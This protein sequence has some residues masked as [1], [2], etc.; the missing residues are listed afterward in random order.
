MTNEIKAVY[1]KESSWNKEEIEFFNDMF[2]DLN[3]PTD[4]EL[5]HMYQLDLIQELLVDDGNIKNTRIYLV[6]TNEFA[7]V[8]NEKFLSLQDSDL[9]YEYAPF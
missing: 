3:E 8:S 5:E 6:A 9:E 4:K 1:I 7:Y 2:Q